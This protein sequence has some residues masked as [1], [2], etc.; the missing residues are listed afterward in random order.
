MESP[1]N[2]KE[3]HSLTPAD[4]PVI[5]RMREALNPYKGLL[6]GAALREPFNH[7]MAQ[8]P[9]AAGVTYEAAT[10]GGV[11]GWWCHPDDNTD[12]AS[13]VLYLHGG[14]YV[15]GSAES[16]RHFAGQLAARV[17]A[18]FFVADYR[19]APEHPFPAAGEDAQAAYQGLVALG[20]QRVAIGGDS[21]GGGLA[22]VT[23]ALTTQAAATESTLLAPR[24]GVAL[25]P[26]TDLAQTSASMQ[27]RAE[28]DFLA[29]EAWLTRNAADYLHGHAAQEPQASPVYGQLAGL[30]PLQLHVGNDEVL[31]DDA[32]CYA[33]RARAAGVAAD[34]HVWEGMPHVFPANV[35]TLEAADHALDLVSA[36]LIEHLIRVA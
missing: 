11:P 25:S 6:S 35:G 26:W 33:D 10:V 9:S 2:P 12:P 17:G 18:D 27:T 22:L 29:T 28:A 4:R 20:R 19:L 15:A 23:L 32:V 16:Y 36:F 5:A 24:A 7:M 3:F 30:P 1:L 34:L 21:A 13:A 31:R 14:A 8:T